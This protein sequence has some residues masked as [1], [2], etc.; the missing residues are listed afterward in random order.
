MLRWLQELEERQKASEQEAARL[1]SEA[2]SSAHRHDKVALEMRRRAEAAERAAAERDAELGKARGAAT[3]TE[4]KVC[5]QEQQLKRVWPRTALAAWLAL[6]WMWTAYVESVWLPNPACRADTLLS[7]QRL[8]RPC[9]F[10]PPALPYLLQ[11][12]AHQDAVRKL[13]RRLAEE[14]S[15]SAAVLHGV[16]LEGLGA[17]D[18]EALGRLHDQ[19]GVGGRVF[20]LAFSSCPRLGWACSVCVCCLL[21]CEGLGQEGRGGIE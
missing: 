18:L 8:S 4:A 19:V 15:R 7:T 2:S 13:E 21:G 6:R 10:P 11:L 9:C 3:E 5:W 14:V 16:G 20:L 17:E 12:R 1:R